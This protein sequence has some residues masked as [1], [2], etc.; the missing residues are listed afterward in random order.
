MNVSLHALLGSLTTKSSWL[1]RVWN[2]ANSTCGH[3]LRVHDGPVTGLSLHATGDYVLT[4]SIDQHWTF[5]DINTGK[6]VSRVTDTSAPVPLTCAQVYLLKLKDDP[7]KLNMLTA[8]E[9]N[10]YFQTNVDGVIEPEW[11]T[12]R[13]LPIKMYILWQSVKGWVSSKLKTWFLS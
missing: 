7:E 2:A 13:S 6:L 8:P 3:V 1:L 10:W 9:Y 11:L 5:S 4:T 12:L